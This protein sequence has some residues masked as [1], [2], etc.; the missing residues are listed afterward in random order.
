MLII[1]IGIHLIIG[2]IIVVLSLSLLIW[3]FL[4]LT[5]ASIGIY[6]FFIDYISVVVQYVHTI[7]KK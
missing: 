3:G 6:I 4:L 7:Y 5:A 2:L 1:D